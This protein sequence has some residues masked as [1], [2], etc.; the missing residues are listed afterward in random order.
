MKLKRAFWIVLDSVGVGYA[1]D[2]AAYD[3]EGAN[4]V[5]HIAENTRLELPHL[6]SIG[7]SR[8]PGTMMSAD[9]PAVGAFGCMKE[10]SKGK[11]TTTGHW[12]MAGLKLD[13]PFPLYPD[14]FPEEVIRPFE[15]MTGRGVLGNKPASGTEILKELGEEHMRTG[16][17]IVYTSGDSVFQIAAHEDIVPIDELYDIC[18]KARALLCGKH[19][20][21][22]VIARPFA[23]TCAAD[24]YRTPRRHDFS[25]E[26]IAPT[27][28][29]ALSSA[30]FDTLAVGKIEDIFCMK[31]ITSSVHSAGN[32][33]CLE[34]LSENMQQDFNGLCFVNLV[35]TDSVYGHR[36]DV[37][38][39]AKAL[40]EFD[41]YLGGMLP[42]LREDDL[43]IITA[44]HGCD[45]TYKGTDHTRERVPLLVWH[46]GMRELIDLGERSTFADIAATVAEGFGLAERFGATSFW[47]CI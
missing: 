37:E 32:P 10:A 29:D 4:T 17:L 31:G 11:D 19:A 7:W 5:G 27:V 38:G 30:G 28:L 2:A 22:R 20:V 6:C 21:G 44:D 24:F 36:R 1:P 39:Y 8:I 45:P 14:G 13:S 18:R 26:P 34:T 25:L 41:A 3:D 33:A 16:K 47:S 15:E 35:D 46:K 9:M 23:G 42:K 43:L 40:M 12:E